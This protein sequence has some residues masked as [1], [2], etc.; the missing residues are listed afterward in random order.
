[1][2]P[3]DGNPGK[4]NDYIHEHSNS[5]VYITSLDFHTVSSRFRPG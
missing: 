1:M 2:E 4:G 5:G 3:Q